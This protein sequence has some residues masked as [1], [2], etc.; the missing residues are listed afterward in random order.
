M[1][2][3]DRRLPLGLFRRKQERSGDT[4][5]CQNADAKRREGP[6]PRRSDDGE[7]SD[8]TETGIRHG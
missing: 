6:A 7:V 3:A 1:P 8:E 5:G 4:G 2:L